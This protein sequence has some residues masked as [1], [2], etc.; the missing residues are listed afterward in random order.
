MK[1]AIYLSSICLLSLFLYGC[2]STVTLEQSKIYGEMTFA[3]WFPIITSFVIWS[4]FYYIQIAGSNKV[5]RLSWFGIMIVL[6][7]FW[8]TGLGATSGRMLS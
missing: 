3:Q 5:W 8:N 4:V 1:D 2:G 7:F 6:L